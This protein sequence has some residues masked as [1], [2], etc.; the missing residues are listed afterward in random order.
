MRFRRANGRKH[1]RD[2]GFSENLHGNRVSVFVE[3]VPEARFVVRQIV[4]SGRAQKFRAVHVFDIRHHH[5]A[6]VLDGEKVAQS[7]KEGLDVVRNTNPECA[8]DGLGDPGLYRYPIALR[9]V[10]ETLD[11]GSAVPWTKAIGVKMVDSVRDPESADQ[12]LKA[13][14]S[15]DDEDGCVV[16]ELLQSSAQPTQEFFD[17]ARITV[18]GVHAL[19]KDGQLVDGEEHRL[20]ICGAVTQQLLAETPPSSCIE[21]ATDLDP[22]V[23]RTDLLDIVGKPAAHRASESL[24]YRTDRMSGLSDACNGILRT[25][26]AL[27]IGEE[28][29]PICGLKLGVRAL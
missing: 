23:E 29:H 12:R 19:E 21:A 28:K 8:V 3:G 9:Q 14:T 16:S 11:A 27:H 2:G 7:G 24:R 26:R 15:G 20:A 4:L 1:V 25:G 6:S 17:A 10:L 13:D 5:P 22:E 18:I